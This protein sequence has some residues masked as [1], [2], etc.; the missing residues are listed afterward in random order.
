[1]DQKHFVFEKQV[2]NVGNNKFRYTHIIVIALG[3][4]IP[5][6]YNFVIVKVIPRTHT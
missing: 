1:M 5:I 3:T 2:L 4:S 6:L